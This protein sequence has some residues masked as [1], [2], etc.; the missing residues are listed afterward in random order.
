VL[1]CHLLDGSPVRGLPRMGHGWP[2]MRKHTE[3]DTEMEPQMHTDER[4]ACLVC[5]GVTCSTALLFE[6]SLPRLGQGWPQMRKLIFSNSALS[7]SICAVAPLSCRSG[8]FVWPGEDGGGTK[9]LKPQMDTDERRC[10]LGVLWR[11]LL[12]RP[13]VRGLPQMGH[14]WPQMQELMFSNSGILENLKP[15]RLIASQ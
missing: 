4:D 2:Q 9:R 14:G 1:W 8:P 11:H 13:P 7:P 5:S 15:S 12:D 3:E 10:R 6:R